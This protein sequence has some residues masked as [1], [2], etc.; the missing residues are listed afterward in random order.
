[1]RENN[2][3]DCRLL[4]AAAELTRN[5]TNEREKFAEFA[6]P[7]WLEQ[8]G[9]EL[10]DHMMGKYVN[11]D[12]KSIVEYL[13]NLDRDN[14]RLVIKYLQKR[15]GG[16]SNKYVI[17]MSDDLNVDLIEKWQQNKEED[18]LTFLIR[19]EKTLAENEIIN[20]FFTI[21]NDL[22]PK[23]RYGKEYVPFGN[24]LYVKVFLK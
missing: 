24:R 5:W 23:I 20:I 10:V 11:N 3:V 6:K 2:L 12:E 22:R 1:M 13:Y 18:L 19:T 15:S 9:E 4:M 21:L 7:Y 14:I 17:D 8:G 16:L